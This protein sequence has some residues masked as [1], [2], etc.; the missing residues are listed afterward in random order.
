MR[1]GPVVELGENVN[2]VEALA[3]VK[4]SNSTSGKLGSEL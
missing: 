3:A 1:E 2:L 4:G